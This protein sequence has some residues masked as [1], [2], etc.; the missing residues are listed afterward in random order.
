MFEILNL[1]EKT[2]GYTEIFK[3]VWYLQIYVSRIKFYST[4]YRNKIVIR[5]KKLR[6]HKQNFCY[7]YFY[8]INPPLIRPLLPKATPLI[9]PNFRQ[10]NW[11]SKILINCSFHERP[12]FFIAEGW[13]HKQGN[14][15]MTMNITQLI[16]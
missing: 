3:E 14:Y 11:D 5:Y 4:M 12:S 13:L 10:M 7:I 6:S 1:R 8:Y 16:K 2:Y 15:H 9:K